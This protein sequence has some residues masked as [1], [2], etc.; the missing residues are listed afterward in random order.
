VVPWAYPRMRRLCFA[1]C[2]VIRRQGRTGSRKNTLCLWLGSQDGVLVSRRT[3][4]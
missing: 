4:V 3:R 1:I 2:R